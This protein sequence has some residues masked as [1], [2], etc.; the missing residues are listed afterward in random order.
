VDAKSA[1][2]QGTNIE[3]EVFVNPPKEFKGKFGKTIWRLKK[4]L[5]G[6]EDSPRAWYL[7]VDQFLRS[8]GCKSV[9]AEP[10]LYYFAIYDRLEGVIATHVDNIYMAGMEKFHSQVV[11]KLMKEFVVGELEIEKFVFC[12]WNLEEK[13]DGSIKVDIKHA[14]STLSDKQVDLKELKRMKK[15]E[16]LSDVW[17]KRFSSIAGSLN[18]LSVSALPEISF[19]VKIL[20]TKFGNADVQDMKKAAKLLHAVSIMDSTITFPAMGRTGTLHSTVGKLVCLEGES[21]ATSLI[22]W[23]SKKSARVTKSSL[24]AEIMAASEP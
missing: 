11:S 22:S 21:G 12:G 6:L 5:Y 13:E 4:V 15:E 20:S 19:R 3:R 7:M 9:T 1:F 8:L 2:L 14:I 16:L 23:S 18:W 10:A 24:A 17:Q